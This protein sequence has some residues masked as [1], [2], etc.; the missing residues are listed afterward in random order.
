MLFGIRQNTRGSYIRVAQNRTF[1]FS[2][3]NFDQLGPQIMLQLLIWVKVKVSN[4]KSYQL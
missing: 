2:I 1:L 3:E 4:S